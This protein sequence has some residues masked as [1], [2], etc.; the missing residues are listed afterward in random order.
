MIQT[1]RR[2]GVYEVTFIPE[3]HSEPEM[4]RLDPEQFEGITVDEDLI[5]DLILD[6]YWKK[7]EPLSVIFVNNRGRNVNLWGNRRY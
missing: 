4:H 3:G 7:G 6:E 2:I 1:S 5:T